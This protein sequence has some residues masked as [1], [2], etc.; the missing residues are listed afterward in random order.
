MKDFSW[1]VAMARLKHFLQATPPRH[2]LA[3]RDAPFYATHR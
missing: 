3:I 1:D 2:L